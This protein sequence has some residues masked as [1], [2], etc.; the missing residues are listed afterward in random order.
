MDHG[1]QPEN[2]KYSYI[3]V[4]AVS[5]INIENE[6]YSD[7]IK[8]LSNGPILQAVQDRL[9]G[10]VQAVFYEH[11]ILP[12]SEGLRIEMDDPGMIMVSY[13]NGEVTN[14]AVSDPTRQRKD[15]H[16]TISQQLTMVTPDDN[17]D[18]KWDSTR[19]QTKFRVSLP[20]EE[21]AGSSVVI[22]F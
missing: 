9:H 2:G 4:P 15:L 10:R 17:V 22:N 7:F 12:V 14:V 19:K 21:W 16:F 11:G 8:I 6:N 3:V 20:Q 13:R 18:L 5:R 1:I